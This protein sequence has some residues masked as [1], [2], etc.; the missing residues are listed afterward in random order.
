MEK[1]KTNPPIGKFL[2]FDHIRFYVG[3]AIQAAHFYTSKFG[4]S[5]YAYSGLETG[6][7][8]FVSHVVSQN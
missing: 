6:N 4:M 1:N 5:Y 7:R 8:D 3:N 2:G